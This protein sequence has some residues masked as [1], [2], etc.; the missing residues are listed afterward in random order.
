PIQNQVADALSTVSSKLQGFEGKVEIYTTTQGGGGKSVVE[1][2]SYVEYMESGTPMRLAKNQESLVPETVDFTRVDVDKLA[3]SYTPGRTPLLYSGDMTQNEFETF[4]DQ[5]AQSIRSLGVDGSDEEQGLCTLI[6]ALESKNDPEAFE[7]FL[8]VANEDDA[9]TIADCKKGSSQIVESVRDETAVME[10]CAP[11]DTNCQYSYEV[12]YQTKKKESLRLKGRK[13]S[14]RVHFETD[15]VNRN[16]S[17]DF[18]FYRHR[19]TTRYFEKRY[20]RYVKY[21]RYI[22]NDNLE[23]PEGQNRTHYFANKVAGSCSELYSERQVDCGAAGVPSSKAPYG[24]VAGTC[25]ETCKV[26]SPKEY[27]GPRGGWQGG[28]CP[29]GGLTYPESSLRSWL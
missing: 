24:L 27:G 20:S 6:R 7:T 14:L 11:G 12:R 19:A 5:M 10:Q 26:E 21:E 8:L 4:S 28:R 16:D 9:T 22:L 1:T 23:E 15:D 3:A 13:V 17:I 2:E 29:S 18:D 25:Y